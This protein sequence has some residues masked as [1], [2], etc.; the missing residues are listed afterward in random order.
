M[1]WLGMDGKEGSERVH[2]I[3]DCVVWCSGNMTINI[4]FFLYL[5]LFVARAEGT[6]S[7]QKQLCSIYCESRVEDVTVLRALQR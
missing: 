7:D 6:E 3:G 2:V 4:V 1:G 5:L